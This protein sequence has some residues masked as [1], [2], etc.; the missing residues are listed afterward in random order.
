MVP[1]TRIGWLSWKIFHPLYSDGEYCMVS[2]ELEVRAITNYMN[3]FA[4]AD[5]KGF[6][7]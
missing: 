3:L 5:R 2:G 4:V 6:I 7:T 1:K